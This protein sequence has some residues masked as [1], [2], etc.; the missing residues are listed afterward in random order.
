[1]QKKTMNKEQKHHLFNQN[2]IIYYTHVQITTEYIGK[3]TKRIARCRHEQS[4]DS[5]PK[6]EESYGSLIGRFRVILDF[7]RLL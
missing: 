7:G 3:K 2:F 4:H 5:G 6:N 1:M